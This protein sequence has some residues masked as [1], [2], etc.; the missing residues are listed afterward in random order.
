MIVN[1]GSL[2]GVKLCRIGGRW[3]F[4]LTWVTSGQPGLGLCL[5]LDRETPFHAGVTVG[6]VTAFLQLGGLG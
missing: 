5:H 6:R 2:R 3:L 1:E 4:S